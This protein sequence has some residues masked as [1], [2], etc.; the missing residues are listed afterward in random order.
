VDSSSIG[1]SSPPVSVVVFDEL[2]AFGI[3]GGKTEPVEDAL[4]V[5]LVIDEFA[6]IEVA[7]GVDLNA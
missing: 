4:A 1:Q 3:A 5:L 2:V 7:V 6:Q